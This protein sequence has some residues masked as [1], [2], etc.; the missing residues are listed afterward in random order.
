[1]CAK[2]NGTAPANLDTEEQRKNLFIAA[3]WAQRAYNGEDRNGN[4]VQDSS[5][6]WTDRG[7]P[8]RYF[9]PAPPNP[10]RVKIVPGNTAVSVYWDASSEQSVDPISNQKDFEGYRL[11]GTNAGADL[12][13]SQNLVASLVLLGE[14]DKPG[15]NVGYN[16]GFGK[17]RLSQPAAFPGDT[18]KY[19]YRFD[20][21]RLLNG[22]QY[23]YTVTAFDA[24]DPANNLSSLESSII[25]NLTRAVPGTLP[26]SDKSVA[27]GVYPNP[28]YARAF[29]DGMGERERKLYFY[30]LPA[31]CEVRIYTLAGDIVDDFEHRASSY[32][33]NDTKWFQ[34][35]SDGTQILAGGE[36]AWDLITKNDQAIATGL[37]L[38]TVKDLDTG[39]IKRGKFLVIK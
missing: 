25:Q 29:W 36:H 18:T 16:T 22:W 28:Y 8:R 10:P 21:P 1:M 9:L 27:I 13:E 17:V 6:I 33:A 38:F 5:E 24:G 4:G 37:Y 3:G 20:I 23:A 2:K 15:N 39:E 26:T 34:K 7:K 31:N 14:F 11:Y 32:T 35:Y 19:S 30:N 12:T